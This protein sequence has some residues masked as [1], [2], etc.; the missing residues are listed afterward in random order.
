MQSRPSYSKI[1]NSDHCCCI[2]RQIRFW[3]SCY[4]VKQ[5]AFVVINWF[6][7]D[8]NNESRTLANQ[9]SPIIYFILFYFFQNLKGSAKAI[10]RTKETNC[11][12]CNESYRTTGYK[13][14]STL[15]AS[16]IM[17]VFPNRTANSKAVLNRTSCCVVTSALELCIVDK[18]A[19]SQLVAFWP[20]SIMYGHFFLK[21]KTHHHQKKKRNKSC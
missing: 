18:W 5:K 15:S 16:W 21:K 17:I 2:R 7:S 6:V 1:D 12:E 11:F 13:T 10:K 19:R 14:G 9:V 20:G 4:K 8:L 3:I